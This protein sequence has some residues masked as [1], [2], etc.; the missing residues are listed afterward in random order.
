MKIVHLENKEELD[1][2]KKQYEKI[3]IQFSASW[4]G[5]CK[6]V[7]PVMKNYLEGIKNNKVVYVYCDID[8]HDSLAEL[9][10]VKSIPCFSVI[11]NTKD[12]RSSI[13]TST[14]SQLGGGSSLS[15]NIIFYEQN[16]IYANGSN[17]QSVC[18]D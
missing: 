7:T 16:G 18:R 3:I 6:R 11:S 15:Q 13:I 5:P 4:C 2:L 10:G 12:E 17:E 9:F 8:E 1:E 14:P